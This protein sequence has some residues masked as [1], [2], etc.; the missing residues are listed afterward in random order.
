MES[1]SRSPSHHTVL[2]LLR[3]W[4]S[5]GAASTVE[6]KACKARTSV[7][8]CARSISPGGQQSWAQVQLDKIWPDGR[9]A[10]HLPCPK[11]LSESGVGLLREAVCHVHEAQRR[12]QPGARLCSQAG[13]RWANPDHG[14]CPQQ[15]WLKSRT[16]LA[17][18]ASS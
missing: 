2:A 12:F 14:Y 13:E 3:L 17:D 5:L 8:G 9:T 6:L 18:L 11:L 4:L 16:F 1:R 10:V 7:P 15:H